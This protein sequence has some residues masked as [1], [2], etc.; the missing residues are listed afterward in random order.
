MNQT[1]DDLQLARNTAAEAGQLLLK[2][3][4]DFGP[5]DPDDKPALKRLRD[6]ADAASH[7][8][9][10]E[11][12]TA[13]RPADTILS[14]EGADDLARLDSERTWI[15]DPLDGTWEYGQQRSDFGVH[16]ALWHN[17]GVAFAPG[18]SITVVDLPAVGMVRTS[19]DPN[20]QL[21]AIPTDRPL[22]V[23]CSRTRPPA[24]LDAI[25]QRWSQRAE[26]DVEIVN[27]GSVGAK[28]E[29]LLQGR[30]EAYL[31]DTGFYEWDLA[32]PMGVAR[33]YGLNV[34]HTDGSTVMFNRNPP[35]VPNV[36]ISHPDVTGDLMAALG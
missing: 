28:V 12:L 11:R 19:A 7:E 4:A 3:R 9:I 2:L 34:T 13:A 24:D 18:L 32:A 29:E 35:Y 17:S 25:V 22:R 21:P 6:Q 14:E 15:V 27:V 5:V 30:A 20:P 36:V 8:L 1:Q 10:M 33:N 31:H 16:I 26:R 23:V